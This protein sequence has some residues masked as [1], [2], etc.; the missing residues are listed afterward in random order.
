MTYGGSRSKSFAVP[1]LAEHGIGVVENSAYGIAGPRGMDS[2][3]VGVLH[4]ALKRGM[5]EPSFQTVLKQLEQEPMYQNT[6]T[7]G[8]TSPRSHRAEGDRRRARP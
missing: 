8:P 4:D 6:A 7:I 3:T 5:E 2:A 1:T